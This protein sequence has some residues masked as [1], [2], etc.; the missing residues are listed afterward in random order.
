[1][2][3]NYFHYE[4]IFNFLAFLCTMTHLKKLSA[5]IPEMFLLILRISWTI[6]AFLFKLLE[7]TI[8]IYVLI[9][10][11]IKET[12]NQKILSDILLLF[13]ILYLILASFL[14]IY[15]LTKH[16]FQYKLWPPSKRLPFTLALQIFY[17]LVRTCFEQQILWKIV[18]SVA[19]Q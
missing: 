14:K 6:I 13:V 1:M 11:F 2:Y 17:N 8:Y 7:R 15:T 4:H 12:L 18:T 16:F 10:N 19:V 5:D 3:L 9:R